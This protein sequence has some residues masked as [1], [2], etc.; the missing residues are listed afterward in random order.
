M[1][2]AAYSNLGTKVGMT[3][4]FDTDGSA[5]PVTVVKAGPCMV[6]QTKSLSTDGY[7]SIQ[8]G[9]YETSF[10]ALNKPLL[11]HLKKVNAPAFKHLREY[12]TELDSKFETGQIISADLFSVGQMVNVTGNS[13]GKGFSSTQKRH[14]FA[15]GPLT[16]GSKN[17]RAPGS[18]GAGTTPGRVIPGKKMPGQLGAQ[19]TT[20]KNLKIIDI[21]IDQNLILLKGSIPGKRG[22]LISIKPSN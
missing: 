7:N 14:N 15:M 22:N 10:K 1:N 18:I 13:I 19:K 17:H 21:Q 6:T 12:K 2:N 16:H 20:V 9:Y 3:Q 8:I 5:I 11:G 4:I